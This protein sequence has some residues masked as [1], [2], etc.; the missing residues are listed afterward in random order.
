VVEG[1]GA[2]AGAAGVG[3]RERAEAV[4]VETEEVA[5]SEVEEMTL[6]E[7]A[8]GVVA[9]AALASKVAVDST[10]ILM[11]LDLRQGV[12]VASVVPLVVPLVASVAL[13]GDREDQDMVHLGVMAAEVVGIAE[14]SNVKVLVGT[15]TGIPNGPD[16]RF[17]T[18]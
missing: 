5:D 1:E 12:Q 4:E 10:V 14:T 9:A 6:P 8:S 13:V 15:M 16:I 11:G 2:P 3:E 17:L 18:R 7:Q